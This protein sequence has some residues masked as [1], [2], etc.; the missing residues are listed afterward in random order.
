MGSPPNP[1]PFTQKERIE[2]RPIGGILSSD[3]AV[4]TARKEPPMCG[5]AG[6]CLSD[7][8]LPLINTRRL[9]QNL[10]MGIEHRGKDATGAAWRNPADVHNLI[11]QKRAVPASWFVRDLS[12]PRKAQTAVLHTRL[13]TQGHESNPVNNH[14][15]T[16][17]GIVGVH[18][19]HCYNDAELFEDMGLTH[20][21]RGEVDSEAIFAAVAWGQSVDD[22]GRRRL[23]GADTFAKC[24]EYVEGTAAVAFMDD[25]DDAEILHVARVYASP[26][27]WAQTEGGSFLFGSTEEAVMTA[28][29]RANLTLDDGDHLQEGTYLRIKDGTITD[30]QKFDAAGYWGS[31]KPWKKGDTSTSL[32]AVKDDSTEYDEWQRKNNAA[33]AAQSQPEPKTIIVRP[34]VPST[35]LRTG[36]QVPCLQGKDHYKVYSDREEAITSWMNGFVGG[37]DAATNMATEL[38]AWLREGDWVITSVGS[39]RAYAQVVRMPQTFAY[40]AYLL[41]AVCEGEHT[42][43]VVYLYKLA[44]EFESVNP[45]ADALPGYVE[46]ALVRQGLRPG[47]VVLGSADASA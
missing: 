4:I 38:H 14:P 3:R 21:R 27:F 29:S 8:D 23:P 25:Q 19:G 5:I 43:D 15:I 10:L 16:V 46:D 17:G 34:D 24:L 11:T 36:A 28:A 22:K 44:S 32:R 2:S 18:N 6:F 37:R 30:M 42:D 7:I 33:I 41:R 40:G 35:Y 9:A 12:M 13:A 20:L 26:L 47:L 39:Q 1:P 31:W 45:K